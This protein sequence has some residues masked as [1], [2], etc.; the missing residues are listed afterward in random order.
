MPNIQSGKVVKANTGVIYGNFTDASTLFDFT[1]SKTF[2]TVVFD[3]I[4]VGDTTVDLDVQELCVGY[5]SGSSLKYTDAVN[6]SSLVDLSN[7]SGYTSSSLSGKT[8]VVVDKTGI[9]G[10]VNGDGIIDIQ[11]V[12]E[13]QKYLANLTTLSSS[14]LA[15]A[16]ID[17]DGEISIKDATEIQKYLAG[18]DGSLI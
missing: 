3:I 8:T 6:K 7:V 5:F 13:I 11:D 9:F 14:Q 4:G 10:D 18:F 12:T 16:D 2:V 1:S 15:N 17:G